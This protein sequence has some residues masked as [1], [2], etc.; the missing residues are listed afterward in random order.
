MRIQSAV[1]LRFGLLPNLGKIFVDLWCVLRVFLSVPPVLVAD[2]WDEDLIAS[3]LSGL[4]IPFSSYPNL[5][6]WSRTVPP[7]TPKSTLQLGESTVLHDRYKLRVYW[8][9]GV[10]VTSRLCLL[11]AL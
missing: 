10:S 6:I 2:P 1:C 9:I 8:P 5:S 3:L 7:I 4:S 11:F